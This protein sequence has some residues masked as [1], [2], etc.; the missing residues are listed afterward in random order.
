M[1]TFAFYDTKN[2][3]LCGLPHRALEH[4]PCLDK[5]LPPA[6]VLAMVGVQWMQPCA[7]MVPVSLLPD[8][9]GTK[10]AG[11]VTTYLQ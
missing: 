1:K 6:F 9:A 3:M 7:A 5:P 11:I 10:Q 8:Q 4:A 2:L